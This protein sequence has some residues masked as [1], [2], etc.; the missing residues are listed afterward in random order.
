MNQPV[1]SEE[2]HLIEEENIDVAKIL[3]DESDAQK[4]NKRITR[5]QIDE[6]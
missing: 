3:F 1:F 6:K 4:I 5:K 2:L